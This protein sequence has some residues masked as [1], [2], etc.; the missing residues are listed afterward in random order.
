MREY[1]CIYREEKTKKRS[2]NVVSQKDMRERNEVS[3]TLIM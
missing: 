2:E 1:A 3:D